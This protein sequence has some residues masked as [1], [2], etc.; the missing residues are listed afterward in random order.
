MKHLFEL[1][2]YYYCM[3]KA[4]TEENNTDWHKVKSE[5]NEANK[6]IGFHVLFYWLHKIMRTCLLETKKK[7]QKM[8]QHKSQLQLNQNQLIIKILSTVINA[9]W[10]CITVVVLAIQTLPTKLR[11]NYEESSSQ[12]CVLNNW[13]TELQHLLCFCKTEIHTI[14][15]WISFIFYV[16]ISRYTRPF[17]YSTISD[18]PSFELPYTLS[19]NVIG[20]CTHVKLR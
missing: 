13:L 7:N 19:T 15:E 3:V 10:R 5:N 11:L 12:T 6:G 16:V 2:F 8:D 17:R 20:T 9:I 1:W 4:L 14:H 18:P